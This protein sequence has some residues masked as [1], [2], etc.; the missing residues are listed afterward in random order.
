MTP[1]IGRVVDHGV[2][3]TERSAPNILACQPNSM[4]FDCQR[5]KRGKFCRRPIDRTLTLSRL[6]THGQNSPIF[7]D[8]LSMWRET[9]RINREL[10]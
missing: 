6:G 2:A 8:Q 7:L 1:T 10:L 4:S 3:L 9:F 5:T